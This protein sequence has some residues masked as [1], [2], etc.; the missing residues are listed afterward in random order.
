[1]TIK[2]LIQDIHYFL[3]K[4]DQTSLNK[5]EVLLL[6]LEKLISKEDK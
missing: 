2:E 3:K 1:M 6:S 4:G 5:A